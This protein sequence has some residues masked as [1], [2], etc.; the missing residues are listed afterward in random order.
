MILSVHRGKNARNRKKVKKP[1]FSPPHL[2]YA[3]SRSLPPA[4]FE[5]CSGIKIPR[6]ELVAPGGRG[7]AGLAPRVCWL[8]AAP[9]SRQ[10][11]REPRQYISCLGPS[12]LITH[13]H[14]RSLCR[15]LTLIVPP[16]PPAESIASSFHYRA[17]LPSLHS[18]SVM[19]RSLFYP[20]D[21]RKRNLQV[22]TASHTCPESA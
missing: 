6:C 11:P 21:S 3:T 22:Q 19:F 8:V 2:E 1:P 14:L 13:Y 15:P 9:P 4:V 20:I 16:E 10:L 12:L 17:P 5:G 18:T 7:Q